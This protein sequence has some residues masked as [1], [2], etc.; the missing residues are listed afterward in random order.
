MT[1]ASETASSPA[2]VSVMTRHD[3]TSKYDGRAPSTSSTSSSSK[4]ASAASKVKPLLLHLLDP[5]G[6]PGDELAVTGEVEAQLLALQLDRRAAGHVGDQ[7]PHV[8][9]DADRVHVLVEVGV[10]LDGGGVQPGLVR[11]RRRADVRLA[12][13]RREVGDLGDRVR[14]PGGV[15]EQPGREHLPVQ[16]E[17][18]VGD[19]GDQVG[20]AGALAVA[21]DRA[22]DVRRACV[23]GGQG[24]GDR[25]AGVVVAVDADA[26]AG[27]LEYVEDDVGDPVGQHAAV[28]VAE[29]DDLGARLGRGPQHLERVRPVL[30]VA[31]EEVLGVEEDRLALRAQVRRRCRAPSRGSPRAWS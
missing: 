15:L 23:D 7:Q 24:V 17:L 30:A 6:H 22:L 25:A 11:E 19:D 4:D 8:V 14:D 29:C 31:V 3:S 28:G 2:R 12:R 16:L 9:A 1:V 21:V 10:D 13:G 5:G 18:E 27:R 20:V 26:R